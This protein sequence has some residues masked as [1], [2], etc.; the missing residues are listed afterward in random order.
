MLRA[1]QR[2]TFFRDS[3]L[4]ASVHQKPT[5]N[6][7]QTTSAHTPAGLPL[8]VDVDGTLLKTDLLMESALRLFKRSPV[9]VFLMLRWLVRG[10]RAMLKHEIA[11]R[12][13][14][15]ASKLP[16]RSEIVAMCHEA[17]NSGREVVLATGAATKYADAIA[18]HL[19][20]FDSTLG[21]TADVNLTGHR[22]LQAILRRC[23]ERRFVYAGNEYK[24]LDIWNHAG[25]AV[26]CGSTR[27]ARMTAKVT[28]VEHHVVEERIDVKLLLRAM[29]IH[30]WAK[31]I[32]V[33]LPFLPLL[34]TLAIADWLLGVAAF[35]SFGLCASSVYL[36]NDLMDLDADRAHPT[37]CH[38]PVPA[39]NLPLPNA[40]GLALFLLLAAFTLAAALLPLVFLSVLAV[41]WALT[42]AYSLD[43]KGRINVDIL[44][45]AL[46][47][48]MRVLGGSAVLML[49]PSFWML[50]FSVFLFF[51]LA[52]VKR[53]IELRA[54]GD[55][56]VTGQPVGRGYIV[57]DIPVLLT[58][59][60]ASGQ[61]AVLVFA[62]YINDAS[63]AAHFAHPEFL[64]GVCPCLFLLINR[65]WMKASRGEV[66][67]D[68]VLFALHDRFSRGIVVV[69]GICVAL[70]A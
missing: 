3:G 1:V 52:A 18:K 19:G 57:K 12:V 38:R 33:F 25:G 39:G 23:G 49:R 27:L 59:G 32:L 56:S 48:T 44:A 24:D 51:S 69:A 7:M 8:Y 68:P 53:L 14:L 20:L 28:V 5:R 2:H 26:V 61:L 16:Y 54:L 62:L 10:G 29:R 64:W 46:L 22:K 30:Q 47:Y 6:L 50:A 55:A 37:K 70:A 42:T 31:N 17:R 34:G 40:I 41:Y 13:D 36:T 35:V 21:T 9:S 4:S 43:L 60:T 58:Q 66:N 45:L 65:V 67:E 11:H 15:D 63:A